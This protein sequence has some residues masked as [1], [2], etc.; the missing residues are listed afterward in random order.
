MAQME[1]NPY[2]PGAGHSPP[3]L[4]GREPEIQA[5]HKFLQQD[6]VLNNVVLTEDENQAIFAGRRKS[7]AA[8]AD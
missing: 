5:F 7:N 3:F 1:L 4:A 8:A 6:Q 2:T